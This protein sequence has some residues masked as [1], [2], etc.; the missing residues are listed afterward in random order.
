MTTTTETRPV[1]TDRRLDAM[2]A[3]LDELTAEIRAQRALR[4][5][6]AELLADVRLI[7]GGAVGN[8]T[9]RLDEEDA[10]RYV[11]FAQSSAGVVDRIVENFD[12]DDVTA[13]GDNVVLIL[14]TVKEMTQPEI[15]TMLQRTAHLVN[16]PGDV[17]A[18]PPSL[19]HLLRDMRDPQVRRGLAR[20]LVLLRSLGDAPA[21]TT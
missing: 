13:L 3:Q 14:E 20:L 6:L 16:E 12:E 15:M 1:E 4:Q 18:E 21:T 5:Q 17:T 9:A 10:R 8:L 11:A 19:L 2:A 7:S